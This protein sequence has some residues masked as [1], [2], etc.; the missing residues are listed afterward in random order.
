MQSCNVHHVIPW[1]MTSVTGLIEYYETNIAEQPGL[2]EFKII[3]L[4]TATTLSE[5]F[6]IP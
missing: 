1:V 4:G 3:L 5:L 2:S 6:S